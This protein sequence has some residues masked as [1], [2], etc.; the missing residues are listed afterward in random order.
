MPA[1]AV[2]GPQLVNALDNPGRSFL[3]KAACTIFHRGECSFTVYGKIFM[4][5]FYIAVF[6]S[7]GIAVL[8]A[9]DDFLLTFYG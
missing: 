2:R 1:P 5:F 3:R 6:S 8:H 7:G 9:T 4:Y